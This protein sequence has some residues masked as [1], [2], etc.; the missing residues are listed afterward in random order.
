[1]GWTHFILKAFAALNLGHAIVL[2]DY[3]QAANCFGYVIKGDWLSKLKWASFPA[4]L[5][6]SYVWN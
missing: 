6:A 4:A 2:T 3:F 5:A 1:M